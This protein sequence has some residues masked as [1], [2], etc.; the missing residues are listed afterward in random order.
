MRR[1]SNHDDEGNVPDEEE[2]SLSLTDVFCPFPVSLEKE[3]RNEKEQ[4][5]EAEAYVEVSPFCSSRLLGPKL[6]SFL[7]NH[8]WCLYDCASSPEAEG[9]DTVVALLTSLLIHAWKT[10]KGCLTLTYDPEEERGA[11]ECGGCKN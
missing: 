7:H 8:C 9:A 4:V 5:E 6:L 3:Q 1:T 2:A 11:V 10:R